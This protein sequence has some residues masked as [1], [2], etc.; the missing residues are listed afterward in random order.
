MSSLNDPRVLLASERT[1]LAWNRTSISLMAF[2][3]VI[4]RFGLFLEMV[5]IQQHVEAQRGVSF[6]IGIFFIAIAI[7]LAFYS[8]FQ[9]KRLLQSLNPAEKP[10]DY[11]LYIGSITNAL[12]GILGI[13]LSYYMIVEM[14]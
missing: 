7:F 12:V 5:R 14:K 2:G 1:L 10:A 8:I 9:H 11:N 4:E 3:F 6:V 13:F